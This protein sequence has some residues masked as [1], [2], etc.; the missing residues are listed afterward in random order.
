MD[1]IPVRNLL[2]RALP[3]GHSGAAM[4]F[5]PDLLVQ[6][7]IAVVLAVGLFGLSR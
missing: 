1:G 4:E 6:L 2:A 5:L 7:L 3:E